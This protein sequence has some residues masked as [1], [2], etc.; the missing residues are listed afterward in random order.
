MA[1]PKKPANAGN[2][3]S[4][5]Q[6]GIPPR[7][8]FNAPQRPE[9][10]TNRPQ[11]NFIPPAE[12][13]FHQEED[14]LV[15]V[16]LEPAYDE[17]VEYRTPAPREYSTPAPTLAAE[18]PRYSEN[19]APRYDTQYEEEEDDEAVAEQYE[20]WTQEDV[21]AARDL[22]E[23]LNSDKSSEILMNGPTSI[24]YKSSGVRNHA[25]EIQFSSIQAYHQF[26][27]DVILD[28]TD[29]HER[30][31]SKDGDN[32]LI[33]GQL[34]LPNWEDENT[35]PLLARVHVIA[36]PVVSEAK[37]TIAKKSR[38]QLTLDD[39]IRNGSLS[40]QMGEF[41][42]AVARGRVTTIFSGLSGSGKTTLLEALSHNFDPNDRVIVV[43]DTPELRFPLTDVVY[44]HSTSPKPGF[45]Q[46]KV[47]T[48]E[49]LVSSTN[50][51][52]PDRIVVGEVRGGEMSEFLVAAN[53]GADGSMT[54]MHASTPKMT[55]DKI[56]TLATKSS[57][58]KSE[59][60]VA[61]D[62]ASTVQIIVQM[63]LIEGQHIVTQIEEVTRVVRKETGGIVTATLFEYNRDRRSF[64]A[65]NRPST[66]LMS[67]FNQRGIELDPAMFR[68][69]M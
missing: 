26:I 40:A 20:N 41:L 69:I 2:S 37:V 48:L 58:S 60:S 3:H 6:H 25:K 30:I 59:Q 31:N 12:P 51:M 62:I 54:T 19:T 55:L 33:E 22:L 1:I 42:K 67:Y 10:P 53:S 63:S 18:A 38:Y 68:G 35:P 44:L 16:D 23:L 15:I 36:P 61:R 13:E 11:Q 4:E 43:E 46:S 32:Y 9:R 66:E 50:R 28:H 5:Q 56:V 64:N 7:G 39:I 49:W 47:V 65:V 17:P 29:T 34:T 24:L 8:G 27:D 52:R 21:K 45:D 14:E 57:T